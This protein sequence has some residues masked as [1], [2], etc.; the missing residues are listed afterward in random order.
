MLNDG[1]SHLDPNVVQPTIPAV[2]SLIEHRKGFIADLNEPSI[3][4]GTALDGLT[5]LGVT[6]DH[7]FLTVADLPVNGPQDLAGQGGL[8]E[9]SAYKVGN[10]GQARTF[11]G[12]FSGSEDA[13]TAL[14]FGLVSIRTV[15]HFFNASSLG[16]RVEKLFGLNGPVAKKDTLFRI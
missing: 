9:F 11:Q 10:I 15:V 3:P 16:L 2:L 8:H 1:L 6:H 4:A 7:D 5:R 12:Q 13:R 14:P